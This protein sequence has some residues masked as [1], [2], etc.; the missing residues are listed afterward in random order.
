[1]LAILF[2]CYSTYTTEGI[3]ADDQTEEYIF[4]RSPTTP[5]PSSRTY[6]DNY[7]ST[8]SP[9]SIAPTKESF[10]NRYIGTII[11]ASIAGF[12]ILLIS[13][14]LLCKEY[15]CKDEPRYMIGVNLV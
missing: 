15:V 10:V 4:D 9:A 2:L 12:A 11:V 3:M 1:M 8:S 13:I 6:V 14:T 5:F 7:R